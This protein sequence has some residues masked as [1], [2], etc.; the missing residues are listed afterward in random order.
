MKDE[1]KAKDEGN[2]FHSAFI[3]YPSAFP[4]RKP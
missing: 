1:K 4:E 3:P 2:V